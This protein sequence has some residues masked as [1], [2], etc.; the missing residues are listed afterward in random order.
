MLTKREVTT[1]G[2]V[3]SRG[4]SGEGSVRVG[5]Y[6][7][8][9]GLVGALARSAREERSKL[10]PHL[11][12]GTLGRFTFVSGT[13]D[14]RAIGATGTV[15]A[16]FMLNHQAFAQGALAR[17]LFALKQLVQGEGT[18]P[19]LFQALWGFVQSLGALSDGEI[20]VAERLCMVRILSSLGYVAAESEI[21]HLAGD[22]FEPALLRSLIPFEKH[23]VKTIN[24]GLF[25][26]G[27]A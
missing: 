8:T 20:H 3:I 26:S 10:R 16:Y 22:S 9:L 4:Q 1:R 14:W 27:L 15:N 24:D 23:L 5:I 18:N 6:T 11:Q 13:R 12:V 21:P 19:E 7:E 17:V 25:A 2:V